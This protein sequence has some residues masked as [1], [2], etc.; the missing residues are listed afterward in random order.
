MKYVLGG[1]FFT[2]KKSIQQK[3]QAILSKNE[4]IDESFLMDL[5][6]MHPWWSEKLGSGVKKIE[7][8][9]NK[10]W[11]NQTGFWLIRN[12]D[13]EIDISYKKCLESPSHLNECKRAARFSIDPWIFSFK[14]QFFD[15][16]GGLAFCPY[17]GEQL[18]FV[19]AHVDH[20][21]PFTFRK[22]FL[23]FFGGKEIDQIEI[24]YTTQ[25]PTFKDKQIQSAWIDFHN[26]LA[27]LKVVSAKA[28]LTILKEGCK[29][30]TA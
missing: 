20:Q 3:V 9:Q 30:K 1:H 22:I 13:S 23:D 21:M 4:P 2:T 8:R 5:F 14:Q 11:Y 12:D 25:K 29:G 16:H 6:E 26:S 27:V 28:N 18:S 24:D 15:D 10:H 7:I 19:G 17:T